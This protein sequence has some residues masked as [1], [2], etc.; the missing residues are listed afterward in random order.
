VDDMQIGHDH[1]TMEQIFAH[2]DENHD[3]FLDASEL[4]EFFQFL[5]EV[6]DAPDKQTTPAAKAKLV[7]AFYGKEQKGKISRTEFLKML[8]QNGGRR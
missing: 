3:G 2:F 5:N 8:A 7:I 6:R 4:E 1:L